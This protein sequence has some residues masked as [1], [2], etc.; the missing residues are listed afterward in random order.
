MKCV[1]KFFLALFAF[2]VIFSCAKSPQQHPSFQDGEPRQNIQLHPH[3]EMPR[4]SAIGPAISLGIAEGVDTEKIRRSTVRVVHGEEAARNVSSGF[5]VAP[6]QIATN[7]HVVA[8]VDPHTLYAKST[9][10]RHAIQGVIAYDTKN[11]LVL[12]KVSGQGTPLPFGDSDALASGDTVFSVGYPIDRFNVMKTHMESV[13]ENQPGFQLTPELLPG[14]SGGPVLNTQGTVIGINHSGSG[15]YGYAIPASTLKALLDR[16]GSVE[17]LA[18]WQNRGSVRAYAYLAEAQQALYA[19]ELVNAHAALNKMIALNPVASLSLS[20]A[21]T[22]R[23]AVKTQLGHMCFFEGDIRKARG[24]YHDALHDFQK[25][26]HQNPEDFSV[27]GHRGY[28]TTLLGHTYFF[29]GDIS[30]ARGYYH[31]ALQEFQKAI[32]R[33]TTHLVYADHGLALVAWAISVTY[34]GHPAKAQ[35]AYHDAL[36]DFQKATHQ[37]PEDAASYANQAYTRLCL[38]NFQNRTGRADTAQT[39][40]TAAITDSNAAIQYD[41][42][43]PYYYH[44]HGV[45]KAALADYNGAIEDFNK[46][47]SL[48]SDF[49]RAYYNRALVKVRL[50]QH[51][52]AQIDF[53]KA[54]ELGLDVEK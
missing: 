21:Y 43:N 49:T 16:S 41:P 53:Q 45:A 35:D 3:Y 54:R 26:I 10:T 5:F 7:I 17:P 15:P 33:K 6:D 4:G 47:L 34:Q 2:A 11:D 20:I 44:I 13:L 39:L 32:H 42:E 40:Y 27:Y 9:D 30:K 22:N 12:L 19:G 24:Y 52:A 48:K 18:D 51:D 37:N 28:A 8:G 29:E 38:A 36:Q 31:D 25:A 23:G 14:T 50:G 1:G 46:T